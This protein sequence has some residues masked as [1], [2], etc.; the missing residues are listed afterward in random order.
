LPGWG[1]EF[2]RDGKGEPEA[3]RLL[4]PEPLKGGTEDKGMTVMP[5]EPE[6]YSRRFKRIPFKA[7][8]GEAVSF[9]SIEVG[10]FSGGLPGTGRD[11]LDAPHLEAHFRTVAAIPEPVDP[12]CTDKQSCD[13]PASESAG[14][15][16]HLARPAG[17]FLPHNS[18]PVADAATP[19]T[20]LYNLAGE[21]EADPSGPGSVPAVVYGSYDGEI[22]SLGV[23]L[24]LDMLQHAVSEAEFRERLSWPIGQP[25]AYRYAWWPRTVALEYRPDK[26]VFAI[27]LEDFARR[28]VSETCR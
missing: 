24:T 10:W 2:V 9:R 8:T 25:V 3:L 21:T 7:G 26:R 18:T 14:A 17:C 4:M 1:A 11:G 12:A 13:P 28:E 5:A 27:S 20:G 16:Q 23:M 6:G 22:V 15:D 19:R